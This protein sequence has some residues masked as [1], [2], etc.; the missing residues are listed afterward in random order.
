MKALYGLIGYPVKHSV[1]PAM[2]NAAFKALS[3]DAEY[4]LFEVPPAEISAFL[5]QL[6]TTAIRGLNVTIPYKERVFEHVELPQESRVLAKVG[7]V[8]TIVRR[9]GRW[10]GFNTDIPGFLKDLKENKIDPKGARVVILGAGGAGRALVYALAGAKA[11]HI[12]LYDTDRA[13][14]DSV[15]SMVADIFPRFPLAAA[16]SV[17]DLGLKRADILINATPV[18]LKATDPCLIDAGD[19]HKRLFVYDLIYNPIRTRLLEE[20]QKAGARISNGLGMLVHQGALSFKH[21]TGADAPVSVMR[22]AALRS[23]GTSSQKENA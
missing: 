8:N 21:F 19:L 15:V 14:V 3:I 12:T 17:A 6:N 16:E 7:A 4:R 2:H 18:G 13:R 23:L 10:C 1:S 11:A 9:D 20:A 22:E 5:S